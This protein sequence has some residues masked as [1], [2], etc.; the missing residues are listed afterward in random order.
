MVCIHLFAA[1]VPRFLVF[2]EVISD[3]GQSIFKCSLTVGGVNYFTCTYVSMQVPRLNSRDA[4]SSIY[5]L[6]T[7]VL[8]KF[9]MERDTN[10]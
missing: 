3:E 2:T 6:C 5:V 9:P 8:V 10:Q 4:V 1:D 7:R